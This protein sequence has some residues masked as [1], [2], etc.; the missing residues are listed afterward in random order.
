MKQNTVDTTRLCNKCCH[1]D[2]ECTSLAKPLAREAL[3][4]LKQRVALPPG[5]EGMEERCY[6]MGVLKIFLQ[7]N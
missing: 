5:S 3:P 4:L 7:N 6:K 1:G 2:L